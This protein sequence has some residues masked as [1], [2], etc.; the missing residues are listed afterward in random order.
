MFL[1]GGIPDKYEVALISLNKLCHP[2]DRG[3]LGL[4]DPKKINNVLEAKI[5]W[6]WYIYMNE[7]WENICI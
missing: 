7:P 6:K 3:G 2:K 1:W 5:C 4:R